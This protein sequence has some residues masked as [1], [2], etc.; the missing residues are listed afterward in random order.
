[1]MRY[2]E[3]K[4]GSVKDAEKKFPWLKEARFENAKIDI[5]GDHLVWHD[6][7]WRDGR[8]HN[9]VWRDGIWHDGSWHNGTRSG[10]PWIF[11]DREFAEGGDLMWYGGSWHDG[12]M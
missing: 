9:G 1:M 2:A 6:G 10:G 3:I 4:G 8:W 7:S 11:R 5:K 12:L